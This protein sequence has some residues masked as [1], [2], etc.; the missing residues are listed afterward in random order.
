MYDLIIIGSGPAGLSSGIYAGR[1]KLKTLIIG[2]E[3]G[4][5]LIEAHNVENWPGF[6]S[7]SGYELMKR[8]EEQVKSLG[9]EI[10]TDLI[11]EIKKEKEG[12]TLKSEKNSYNGKTIIL[13]LGSNKNKLN[14]KGE[15]EFLGKGVNY[16]AT[17]DAPMYKDKIAVVVGGSNSAATSALLLSKYAK[18]VYILYRKNEIRSEPILVEQ[19]KK[20]KKIEIINNVNIK[21][22][23]GDRFVKSVL[24]DNNKEMKTDG[25]FIEAG[26]VPSSKLA[27]D[28][29]IKLNEKG[30]IIVDSLGRT[31]VEGVYA[32]G[33]VTNVPLKQATVASSNG[34]IACYSAYKFI[35]GL[36]GL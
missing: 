4:G 3:T 7:I 25:V 6:K 12:F 22:I 9:I 14:V 21:E 19:I 35:K 16:C 18:K 20:N 30:E 1:Y 23:K 28:L 24:L 15:K 8:I 5:M 11:K 13:A 26:Y 2:N 10:K 29:R 27:S 32:A 36:K 34:I 33:D 31:N 17:C